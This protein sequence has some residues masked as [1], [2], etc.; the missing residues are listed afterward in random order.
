MMGYKQDA[1]EALKSFHTTKI[2][3]QPTDEDITKLSN[4][5]TEMAATIPTMNG[6]S[7][8]GHMGVIIKD[9]LY[10]TFSKNSQS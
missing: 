3:G 1:E 10:R 7:L 6:G 4:E 8:H 2:D 5:L 9:A